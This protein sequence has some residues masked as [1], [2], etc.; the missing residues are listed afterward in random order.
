MKVL[1]FTIDRDVWQKVCLLGIS[2]NVNV[3]Y[4]LNTGTYEVSK[5]LSKELVFKSKS[6][7]DLVNFVNGYKKGDK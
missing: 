3:A 1:K 7:I 6:F 5:A 4:V 2:K